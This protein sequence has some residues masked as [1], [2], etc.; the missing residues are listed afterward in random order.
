[1]EENPL[2]GIIQTAPRVVRGVSLYSR[3]LAFAN[4]LYSPLYLAGLNYWQ[5]H[6]GNY[7]G[8]NAIIRVKPF[9]DHCALPELPGVE[10]FGGRILSHDFVEAALMR[11]AGWAVWLA[12]DIEGSYE[13]GPPTLIESAK[14]DRRWC[15]G[16]IQHAWLLAARGFRPA[17]RFHLLMG[18]MAYASSPLWLLFLILSTVDMLNESRG[19]A[20]EALAFADTT[21]LFGYS[22]AIPEALT[23]FVLTML[24]LFLPKFASVVVMLGRP[25][26]VALFGGRWRLGLSAVLETLGSMLLAPVNMI[27]NTKFVIFTLLGQGVAWVT[28]KR[29][30]D[31]DGTDWREAILT[32]GVMTVFGIVWGVSSLILIP[33]YFAWLSPVLAGLV[34]SIPLSIFL[35]KA[36]FGRRARE[37]GIFLTPE[38]TRPPIDLDLLERN[39]EEC[40]RHLLPFEP[41]RADYGLMQAVLDPYIN[42]M[43]V[44]LLRQ[45]R[46]SPVAREWFSRLQARLLREGPGRFTTREKMALLMDPQSMIQLHRELWTL[47]PDAL[48]E[49]WRLA[50]R[51]Y[52]VLAAVPTTALYR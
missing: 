8:H 44:A 52:N 16:N 38:E 48:A 1:M 34:L 37:L 9:M 36:A 43:H 33:A 32:H 6:E 2:A 19:G 29:T 41:L 4:R 23:L 21:S 50:M 5:Q 40:Y 27:F 24:L 31:E 51:Q 25:E 45:R 42:A 20:R 11:K 7:W 13:E 26:E 49:W 46:T 10:P 28:Q 47:P 14:R 35:S 30:A 12:S 17:N 22:V 15:Q 39:L 18:I 3:L